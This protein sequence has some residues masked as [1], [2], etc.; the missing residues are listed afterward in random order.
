MRWNMDVSNYLWKYSSRWWMVWWWLLRKTRFLCVWL[1]YY[2]CVSNF[3]DSWGANISIKSYFMR[4]FFSQC[5]QQQWS[6]KKNASILSKL[7]TEACWFQEAKRGRCEANLLYVESDFGTTDKLFTVFFTR[8]GVKFDRWV[9]IS[10]SSRKWWYQRNANLR[11]L[12]C[13]QRTLILAYLN[14]CNEELRWF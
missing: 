1:L 7:P 12:K 3:A 14:L 9:K 10:A 5:I 13:R 6:V 11:A 2:M 4:S 8:W